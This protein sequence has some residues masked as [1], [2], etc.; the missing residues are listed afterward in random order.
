M[1]TDLYL[2]DLLC[3]LKHASELPVH[4]SMSHP[5]TS[6]AIWDMTRAIERKLFHE[7]ALLWRA[8]SL[9]RRLVGDNSYVPC[10]IIETPDDILN[11]APVNQGES[12]RAETPVTVNGSQVGA[13]VE[14]LDANSEAEAEKNGSNPLK[15]E[16]VDGSVGDLP[17]HTESKNSNA[18][19]NGGHTQP[20]DGQVVDVNGS[21]KEGG[22][23][24]GPDDVPPRRMTTRAQIANLSQEH[25]SSNDDSETLDTLPTPHPLFLVPD[26]LRQDPNF[27][28]PPTEAED[29]RRL[30][31]SYIQKQEETVRGFE[32]MLEN[33]LRACRMKDDV[34]E[35][36]NAEGHLGEMSDGEDW[37]DRKKWGLAP[38]EDLKK[39]AD[40]DEAEAVDE[41]RG[42]RGRR[43][44]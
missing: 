6:K 34:W 35:W 44:Q 4:P 19:T 11:F 43:R 29:T 41:S 3:P 17:Q 27:G 26:S 42:K 16:D 9:H 21:E 22:E 2:L 25:E 23:A 5:Y 15:S 12:R 14:M 37:Y 24:S 40:E 20:N 7:R 33:L 8:R 1:K 18:H 38:G 32:Q 39:G 31:W 10:G 30:L 28:L 36:C 13:D